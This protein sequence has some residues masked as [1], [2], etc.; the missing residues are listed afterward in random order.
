MKTILVAIVCITAIELV[1]LAKGVNGTIL[2]LV[3]G[4]VAGLGGLA[5]KRPNII[6]RLNNVT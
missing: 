2:T 4:T 1:A 5:T 3:V 6:K